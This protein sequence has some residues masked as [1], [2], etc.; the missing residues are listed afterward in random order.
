MGG[1]QST[2]NLY[3]PL[4]VEGDFA[5]ANPRAVVLAPDGGF[6]AGP[7]G[8]IVGNF[9]WVAEDGRTV[10][11]FAT[12][13]VAPTGY[14]HRDQQALITVY[15]AAA[16]MLIPP[17]FPVTLHNAG[18]FFD[19]LA[20]GSALAPGSSTYARFSD[21]AL[22][23]SL[24]TGASV[25]AAIGATMTGVLAAGVLTA[26]AVTGLI[27]VGDTLAGSG[28]TAGTVIL[29]QLSGT[30]GG[31]GTYQTSGDQTVSS[32]TMTSYGDVLDVTAVSSGALAV[33]DA[34]SGTG[35]PTG[36]TIASQVSGATGGV[37]VYTID[38][39][40][41]AYAASTTVTVVAGI[42]TKFV[43]KSAAAVGELVKISTWGN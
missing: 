19:M 25:T 8:V 37:G 23:G 36:A 17:G 11:S 42:L 43:A 30:A 28:V 5:S 9:A 26:S 13:D 41:S 15:L 4:A 12:G 2:V 3:N 22:V 24:P 33:G 21:G 34:I 38:V 14:V 7:N 29:S 31:A 1:F 40:A 39:P 10:N 32:E 27:S 35:V 6:V 16:S 20:A 18:D